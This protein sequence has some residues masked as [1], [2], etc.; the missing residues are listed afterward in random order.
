M[1][2]KDTSEEDLTFCKARTHPGCWKLGTMGGKKKLRGPRGAGAWAGSQKELPSSPQK[3][4]S[5]LQEIQVG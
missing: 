4:L 3:G 2:I 5:H 1:V